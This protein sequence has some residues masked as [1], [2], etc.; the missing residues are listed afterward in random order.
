L[1]YGHD[2]PC[3]K[4]NTTFFSP[5]SLVLYHDL[6]LYRLCGRPLNFAVG[7][8]LDCFSGLVCRSEDCSFPEWFLPLGQKHFWG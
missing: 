1:N 5:G 7:D 3:E 2:S 8:L 6:F 4:C